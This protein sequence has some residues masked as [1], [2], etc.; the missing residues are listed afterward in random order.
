MKFTVMG[1]MLVAVAFTAGC[2]HSEPPPKEQ[3]HQ[4]AA[5]KAVLPATPAVPSTN[6][7]SVA[8]T[9]PPTSHTPQFLPSIKPKGAASTPFK[10]IGVPACDQFGLALQQCM[11]NMRGL[12]RDN[13]Q[14]LFERQ[15]DYWQ[16]QLNSGTSA[17][18]IANQCTT[19]ATQFSRRLR[20]MGCRL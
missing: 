18:D 19:F 2:S 17:A 16:K 12:S 11:P 6:K 10:K 7:P 4:V 5:Q 8:F 1:A 15:L 3:V 9:P 14:H 20:H 13:T